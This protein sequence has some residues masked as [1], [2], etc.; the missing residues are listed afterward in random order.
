M[1]SEQKRTAAAEGA[2]GTE[3]PA[4]PTKT[5]VWDDKDMQTTYANVINVISTR[6]EFSLFFGTNQTW[7]LADAPALVVK[8]VNRVL[9]TPHAARRLQM[10]LTERLTEYEKRHGPVGPSRDGDA[11]AR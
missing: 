7:N 11:G 2:K 10:L 5:V 3:A 8:L 6:E 4:E 9:L 1:T